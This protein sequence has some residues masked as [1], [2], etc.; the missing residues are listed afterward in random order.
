MI[1]QISLEHFKC[2]ERLTLPLGSLTLLSGVN[3]SGKSSIIQALSLLHQSVVDAEWSGSLVLDGSTQTLGTDKDIIDKVYGR[4][5]FGVGLSGDGFS[6]QWLF[7]HPETRASG[8]VSM[9]TYQVRWSGDERVQTFGGSEEISYRGL[10]PAELLGSHAAMLRD[11]LKRID[12]VGAERLGPREI[13]RLGHEGWHDTVG[14]HGE[15]APGAIWWFGDERVAP[16]L[17]L[18]DAS[19]TVRAQ[20]QAWIEHFFPGVVYQID[21]VPNANA[22]TLG[23]RTSNET[24]FHRPQHVGYGITHVLPMLVAGVRANPPG[25]RPNNARRLI[26]IENPEVHLHPAGQAAIGVFLARVAASGATVIVET[27]SDH[28]LNGVRRAVRQK[29]LAHDDVAIHFFRERALAKA[30]GIAQVV[31]PRLDAE[32]NIDHWPSG[33]FDQFD[34]DMNYFAGL[35]G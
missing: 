12:H 8:S 25:E 21:R 31:S 28:V 20:V 1:S 34:R 22:L 13:Y 27:H 33:F 26:L 5:A 17:C 4:G 24:D 23:V 29:N 11:S 6:A 10:L 14:I 7:G 18:G 30:E 16:T 2:F 35:E 32:G 19:P 9:P 3:A 15:R